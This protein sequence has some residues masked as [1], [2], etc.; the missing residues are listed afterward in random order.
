MTGDNLPV[1]FLPVADEVVRRENPSAGAG[2]VAASRVRASRGAHACMLTHLAC[3]Q[4]ANG[5][6]EAL[7]LA[8]FFDA[9]RGDFARRLSFLNLERAQL[10]V[11]HLERSL[12]LVGACGFEFA[13]RASQSCGLVY[14]G[15]RLRSERWSWRQ[16]VARS[17]TSAARL[18]VVGRGPFLVRT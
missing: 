9:A 11:V 8:W 1:Y 7:W 10:P 2:V 18:S 12:S 13:S 3:L 5:C 15:S 4:V 17:G 14:G 6:A 16:M